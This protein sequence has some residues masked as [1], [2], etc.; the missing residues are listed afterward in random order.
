MGLV[1]YRILFCGKKYLKVYLMV[2]IKY[3]QPHKIPLYFV[4]SHMS[5]TSLLRIFMTTYLHHSRIKLI[6]YYS[7]SVMG[8]EV[9]NKG[10]IHPLVIL[11]RINQFILL[12][13]IFESHKKSPYC[14]HL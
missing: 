9:Q 12:Q 13:P 7:F 6:N 1:K 5:P 8:L 4:G 11:E 10:T 2:V 3:M 14:K